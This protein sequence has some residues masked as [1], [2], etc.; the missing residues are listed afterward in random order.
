MRHL[1]ETT[2]KR[3]LWEPMDGTINIG[4]QKTTFVDRLL[5][6]SGMDNTLEHLSIIKDRPWVKKLQILQGAQTGDQNR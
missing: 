1:E 4:T 3:S 2:N 6:D 5:V